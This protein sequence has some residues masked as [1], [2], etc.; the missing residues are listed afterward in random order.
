MV[1]LPPPYFELIY[2][3]WAFPSGVVPASGKLRFSADELAHALFVTGRAP[4]DERRHGVASVHEWLHRISVIPAYVRRNDQAE[5]IRSRLALDLDRSELVGLS[6]ALGQ[7]LTSVFCRVELSARH[8]MHIDRYANHY[9]I[10]FG[11]TRKR[12]DL[13]G[14]APSGWL[15]AEAKG[16]SRAMESSLRSKLIAQKRSVISIGGKPPWLAL[17][18]VAS[19]PVRRAG[20]EVDVFDPIENEQ[21]G[22]ELPVDLDRFMLA[23]YMPFVTA[24]NV[25]ETDESEQSTDW[26]I[27]ARFGGFGVRVRML[28]A[29]YDRV[30]RAAAGQSEGLGDDVRIIL[31]DGAV[32]SERTAPELD[33]SDRLDLLAD[34]TFVGT[35]WAQA[36]ATQDW[37]A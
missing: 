26:T 22:I 13:F 32:S 18:C 7:A 10:Q 5:L 14:S 37:N 15:V 35:D 16:R 23:Y 11:P 17:G 31:S 29:L 12:S 30:Q 4:G 21:E 8:L 19:F 1:R 6:Y 2:R 34:G 24:V 20:M 9:G 33:P 25:G 27:G 3:T 36:L 28:R